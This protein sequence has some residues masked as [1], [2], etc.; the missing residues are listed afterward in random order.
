MSFFMM[1]FIVLIVQPALAQNNAQ[2][3]FDEANTLLEEGN[4]PEALNLYRQIEQ[5]GS[6]SGALF[7]NMGIAATEI[8]SMGLAKYYFLKSAEFPTSKDRA[9]DALEYVNS[10]F[11]RQSATLPKL[12]WDKAVDW[13]KNGP[14]STGVFIIG[15]FLVL[16]AFSVVLLHWFKIFTFQ[17]HNF[18]ITSLIIVSIA[19]VLLSFYVDYVDQRYLEGVVTDREI[20]VKQRPA[21]DA[22]LVSLAYEGYSVTVD[23]R[24]SRSS[25]S[26]LYVRLGNG[27][28]GWIPNQG[29][30][31]F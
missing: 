13:L 16:I 18:I 4:Y 31:T 10:Q 7:L 6:A 11:S 17:K 15:F 5:S 30:R 22:D 3:R 8:D 2:L 28:Y 27:Q 25:D 21:E 23:Q 24:L 29:V 26:W 9:L 14:G 19:T 20:Q 12:P 1:L